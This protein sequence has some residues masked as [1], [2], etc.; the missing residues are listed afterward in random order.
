MNPIFT[1]IKKINKRTHI[2]KCMHVC[3]CLCLCVCVCVER[4][5]CGTLLKMVNLGKDT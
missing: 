5:N 2:C 4:D 1:W 3:V